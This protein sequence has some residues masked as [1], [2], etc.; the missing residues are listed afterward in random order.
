MLPI[1]KKHT[2][3]NFTKGNSGRRYIVIHYTGNGTDTAVAN[4]NYFYNVNR[5]ASA[6]YFV[7]ANSIYEVV[8]PTDT[9]W[10]VGRN[11]GSNNL[12][13]KC[14]NGNSISVEMCSTNGKISDATFN[15][16]VELTK[17]LMKKYNIPAANV[18]RHYDVCS[19]Q[20]P[21]WTGWLP[22]NQSIWNKFKA[23]IGSAS[24]S[25]TTKPT[26]TKPATSTGYVFT[27]AVKCG[28]KI[29]P[30][31]TNLNDYAGIQGKAI[32]DV[33]IKVNKGSVKY[34]VH[35]KGGK[36][37]PYVTGYNWNDYNNGYAGNGKPI[38]AIQVVLS[39]AGT[40]VAQYRVSPVRKNYF[41][42][43]KNAQTSGG[44]DGYAGA[45]GKTIDRFQITIA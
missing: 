27:Y 2:L 9:A 28:G 13:G 5:G 42:W 29:L 36:W 3:V 24:T 8:A 35:V 22:P 12:F 14:K 23:K 4:A 10:A 41:P 6:H 44:Q 25:T 15:N 18:V 34:R 11:F 33:A 1:T 43:Q 21:G 39:G 20:C 26:T 32:T 30:A 45:Y 17:A 31:V 40:K 38:D 7:D 37:L 19:K 16:T